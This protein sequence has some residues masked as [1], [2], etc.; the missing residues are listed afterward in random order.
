[1]VNNDTIIQK[2]F[3][4]ATRA[5]EMNR[6]ALDKNNEKFSRYEVELKCLIK[7]LVE[8]VKDES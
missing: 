5:H 4:I 8:Y 1:M 2:C 6:A 7:K 3:G